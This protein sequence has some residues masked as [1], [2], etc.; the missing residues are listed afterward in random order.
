MA[1][2]GLEKELTE[3]TYEAPCR[4]AHNFWYDLISIATGEKRRT[5]LAALLVCFVLTA[6]T[7]CL[8]SSVGLRSL[9]IDVEERH[10]DEK[11]DKGE[12][13]QEHDVAVVV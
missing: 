7:I 4:D 11:E 10:E 9:E 3:G 1:N 12:A 6:S 2:L 13:V 8:S 5:K